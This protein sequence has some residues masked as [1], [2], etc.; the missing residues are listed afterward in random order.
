MKLISNIPQTNH[1]KRKLA[2]PPIIPPMRNLFVFII[3]GF[4]E[5]NIT[6]KDSA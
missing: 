2:I 4:G 6:V 1:P 5:K 3:F